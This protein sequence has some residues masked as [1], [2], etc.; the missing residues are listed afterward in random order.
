MTR[1]LALIEPLG[2]APV[3]RALTLTII[4][5]GSLAF[6]IQSLIG[7]PGLIAILGALVVLA[8]ASMVARRQQLD[9]DG[10]LP[11]SLLAFVGW[12]VASVFWSGYQWA[13]LSSVLYQIAFGALGVYVALT[14]DMIQ[15][16][17]AI[18][19]VLRF[20]LAGSLVMEVL[21][22][23]LFDA[24]FRPLNIRGVITE[25]GPIQGLAGDPARLG[26][27]ALVAAITFGV[28]MLARSVP[29]GVSVGSLIAALVVILLTQSTVVLTAGL[30]VVAAALVLTA[31][32]HAPDAV[33][34]PLTWVLI[35]LG[36]LG[37]GLAAMLRSSVL[38]AFASSGQVANR[39]SLWA[40]V[41]QF[42]TSEHALAGWGWIG[43]WRVELYP[44]AVFYQVRDSDF[45]SAYNAFLDVFF[46]V[47]LVGLAIFVGLLGLVLARS[48]LLAV[49]Q[50]SVVYLW[51]ALVVVALVATSITESAVLVEFGWLL[52]VV[53]VVKSADKLS[54]RRAFERLRPRTT[55][56]E[57][58]RA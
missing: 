46:Q 11:I 29:L 51:P 8:G 44:F 13:T 25:G 6:A 26:I 20:F 40:G 12:C 57:L 37:A 55:G 43:H 31:V 17:R 53:C 48:W 2:S 10:I 24:P 34:L 35:V 27:I 32:R 30:V 39:R 52:L 1:V 56:P 49:R 15:I 41:F 42:G 47:G 4:A 23:I 50:R 19:G 22:G 38:D 3:V 54:W 45:A 9:W 33:K 18:G 28:E 16:V 14:R 5:T 36:I 7:W 21:T 58:P